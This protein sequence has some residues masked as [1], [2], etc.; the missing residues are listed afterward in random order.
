MTSLKDPNLTFY[1]TYDLQEITGAGHAKTLVNNGIA[2]PSNVGKGSMP[3]YDS[4]LFDAGVYSTGNKARANLSKRISYF[5]PIDLDTSYYNTW[6]SITGLGVDYKSG[7]SAGTLGM[8]TNVGYDRYGRLEGSVRA[9]YSVTPA[10][11]VFGVVNVIPQG[12]T[13]RQQKQ[14][15]G[16]TSDKAAGSPR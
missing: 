2:V 7:C 6:T 4:K 3:N 12:Y 1:Q 14:P 5:E 8:C 15:Y 13:S 10:F 16:Y 9:T 11:S